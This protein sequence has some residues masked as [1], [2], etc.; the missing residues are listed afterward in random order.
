[1]EFGGILLFLYMDLYFQLHAGTRPTHQ[2]GHLSYSS[3]IFFLEWKKFLGS[4]LD[5]LPVRLLAPVLFGFFMHT[6]IF[7]TNRR[8]VCIA[9]VKGKAGVSEQKRNDECQHLARQFQ[10]AGKISIRLKRQK[11]VC[12]K[13]RGLEHYGCFSCP[14]LTC[15]FGDSSNNW[16]ATRIAHLRERTC[17]TM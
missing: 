14:D 12:H 16:P 7:V 1:M 6:A 5:V 3:Q 13:P 10:Q 9:G 11:M 4:N 17:D 15:C 2:S 8:V